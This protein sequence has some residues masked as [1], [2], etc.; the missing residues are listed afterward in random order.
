M[1]GRV[2]IDRIC[3]GVDNKLRKDQ[4]GFR[5]RK[6]TSDQIFILHNIIEQFVYIT[7]VDFEKAFD[8]V[9]RESLWK[10]MA[11]Y[12]ITDKLISWDWKHRNKMEIYV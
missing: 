7:F 11:S 9:H 8:F 12:G 2:I 1:F 4:A 6:R 5:K 10:I 3:D